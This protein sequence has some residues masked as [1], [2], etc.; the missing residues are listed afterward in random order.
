[1]RSAR[2]VK[3]ALLRSGKGASHL[4]D[5]AQ[6]LHHVSLYLELKLDQLLGQPL[7]CLPAQLQHLPVRGH[8]TPREGNEDREEFNSSVNI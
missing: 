2:R 8:R 1:M 5:H 4:S 6:R 3:A 7:L